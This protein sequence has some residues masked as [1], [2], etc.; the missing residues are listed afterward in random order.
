[1]K[2]FRFTFQ[3]DWQNWFFRIQRYWSWLK[4]HVPIEIFHKNY[5]EQVVED[6]SKSLNRF[7]LKFVFFNVN[8]VVDSINYYHQI[9]ETF[10]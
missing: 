8:N 4:L 2:F 6:L 7:S 5:P 10:L 1:M 9:R 3:N